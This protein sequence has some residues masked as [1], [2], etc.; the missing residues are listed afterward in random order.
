VHAIWGRRTGKNGR[1][2]PAALAIAAALLSLAS[3]QAHGTA[4]GSLNA[5]G[6]LSGGA[7]GTA[8]LN[9][10]GS[11]D[12][13]GDGQAAIKLSDRISLVGNKLEY[14]GEISF[15]Y[16]SSTLQGE[17]T[18]ATLGHLRDILKT[19]EQVKIHV[20]GHADSRGDDEYNLKLS[21][22]RALAIARWLVQN[23][24][25]AERV[26]S[27]GYGVDK[28]KEPPR[29]RDKTGPD[30][31]FKGDTE[32][33]TAWSTARRTV[34]GVTGGLETLQVVRPEPVRTAVVDRP[35]ADSCGVRV[36]GRLH[37]GGPATY[38]G[39]AFALEPTCFLELNLG[40]GISPKG[41]GG[42][43]AAILLGR[44]TIWFLPTHSPVVN[45]TV[46]E[47][48]GNNTVDFAA[49]G[50][51]YGYRSLDPLRLSILLGGMLRLGGPA[52][53]I[54]PIFGEFSLGLLWLSAISPRRVAAV[55]H[56]SRTNPGGTCHSMAVIH[57]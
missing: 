32:C 57:P 13:R 41:S 15:K 52:G 33:L 43:L 7:T 51:G 37:V 25:A 10:S 17:D 30:S 48:R 2:E 3:C 20:E 27:K 55:S 24:V 53:V 45:V 8:R 38:G 26:T 42:E 47:F 31:N 23:G 56:S 46:G 40:G 39:L 9:V 35:P 19:N 44:G 18:F 54:P 36:G 21:G 22:A 28:S 50:A 11:A 29:C 16:D 6:S 14:Q 1:N 49:L 12:V 5:G 34:I 4:S